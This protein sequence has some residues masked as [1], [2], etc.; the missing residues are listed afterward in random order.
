MGLG[1][2]LSHGARGLARVH[3]VVDEQPS[4]AIAFH[5]FEPSQLALGL[6]GAALGRRTVAHYTDSVDEAD[7]QLPGHQRGR[8]QPAAGDGEDAF[9]VADLVQERAQVPRVPVQLR[10]GN[11]DLVLVGIARHESPG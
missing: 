7:I 5:T 9:P 6:L 4:V 11:N 10:P 8:Y 3:E 2:A 1:Q